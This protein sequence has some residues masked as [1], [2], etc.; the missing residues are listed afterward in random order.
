MAILFPSLLQI[1]LGI[2]PPSETSIYLLERLERALPNDFLVYYKPILDGYYPDIVVYRE[3]Y[4]VF[5]INIENNQEPDIKQQISLLF[6]IRKNFGRNNEFY[7]EK[8]MKY[9][10]YKIASN[11]NSELEE[12]L[13]YSNPE[14]IVKLAVYFDKLDRR[15]LLSLKKDINTYDIF[16][17]SYKDDKL[18]NNIINSLSTKKTYFSET[19][20]AIKLQLSPSLEKLDLGRRIVFNKQQETL[21]QV[22]YPEEKKVSGKA[23]SGKSLVLAQKAVNAYKET[24]DKV[25]ILCFNI[26]LVNYIR[27]QIQRFLP[28]T[29][30]DIF[31]ITHFHDFMR[32]IVERYGVKYTDKDDTLLF[33]EVIRTLMHKDLKQ[34]DRYKT[35]L[36]D[37]GQDFHSH[38]F[39]FLKKKVL[40]ENGSYTIF[41]DPKQNIYEVEQELD[42]KKKKVIKTNVVGRWNNL[43]QGYRFG[44]TIKSL[45][46]SYQKTFLSNY[47]I[48]EDEVNDEPDL[49]AN[50]DYV[51]L[52][53]IK[54]EKSVLGNTLNTDVFFDKVIKTIHFLSEKHKINQNDITILGCDIVADFGL[55]ELDAHLRLNKERYKTITTF[56]SKEE[57]EV[58]LELVEK[59][60]DGF[61]NSSN[62]SNDPIEYKH[63]R[64]LIASFSYKLKLF[65]EVLIKPNIVGAFDKLVMELQQYRR[66]HKKQFK[67]LPDAIKISSVHSFKGWESHCVILLITESTTQENINE[68]VYVGITRAKEILY[69]IN[70]KPEFDQ[71]FENFAKNNPFVELIY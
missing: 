41:G 71:F 3:G 2:T 35:I 51:Y 19:I 70:T 44:T 4:G 31:Y 21:S 27:L 65:K 32:K 34:E 26:T 12:N 30:D 7:N 13:T 48:I 29:V 43:K 16:L 52:D 61:E 39:D 56:E 49:L 59:M 23:G 46:S 5:I 22:F 28:E 24:K 50:Q 63:I 15:N 42:D 33:N 1:K 67:F 18:I 69:I 58:F 62:D 25:L 14:S 66:N 40:L 17:W 38:W 55:V 6:S 53:N 54:V 45:S 10:I 36:I 11:Y 20:S 64:Q 57:Q 60:I 9:R 47:E 8:L 68:L 37:E